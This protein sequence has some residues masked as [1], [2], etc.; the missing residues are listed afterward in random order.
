M[1]NCCNEAIRSTLG[2]RDCWPV[3]G[4]IYGL[5]DEEECSDRAKRR[6]WKTW[7]FMVEDGMQ[8]AGNGPVSPIHY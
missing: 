6:S 5:V 7:L 2:E 1:Q 8:K 3:T 4:P